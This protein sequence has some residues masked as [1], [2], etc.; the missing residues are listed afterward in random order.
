MKSL[1]VFVLTVVALTYS[2]ETKEEKDVLVLDEKNFDDA[3]AA[4]KHILVEFCK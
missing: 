2:E 1:V 4:H 3:V